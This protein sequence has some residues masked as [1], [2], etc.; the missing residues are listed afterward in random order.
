MSLECRLREEWVAEVNAAIIFNDENS[1]TSEDFAVDS[2]RRKKQIGQMRCMC[3]QEVHL[4]VFGAAKL[5][6]RIGEAYRLRRPKAL[7]SVWE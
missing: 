3:T 2:K 4:D 1:G 5:H 6:F 7:T